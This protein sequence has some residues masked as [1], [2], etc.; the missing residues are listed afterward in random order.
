M[1]MMMMIMMMIIII[2]IIIFYDMCVTSKEKE[3]DPR[4]LSGSPS[5]NNSGPAEQILP[6]STPE[7]YTV[8]CSVKSTI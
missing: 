4:E 7:T 3:H 5:E 8:R 6:V 2:I 1:I